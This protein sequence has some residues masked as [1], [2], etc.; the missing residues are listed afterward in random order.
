MVTARS[1]LK[2]L[3]KLAA[4]F[5]EAAHPRYP[6][7]H[8]LGGQFMRT[9]DQ[10]PLQL[11]NGRSIPGRQTTTLLELSAIAAD[12]TGNLSEDEVKRL[13]VV[14][15]GFD[16][17]ESCLNSPINKD[18]ILYAGERVVLSVISSRDVRFT[19]DDKYI[20][21]TD[22]D[23][24]PKPSEEL[25]GMQSIFDRLLVSKAGDAVFSN[26]PANES[27][28]RHE[29]R[30]KHYVKS[31]F[32]PTP[33]RNVYVLDNRK[34]QADFVECL[35]H[36]ELLVRGNETKPNPYHFDEDSN[37]SEIIVTDAQSAQI[38]ALDALLDRGEISEEEHIR[39]LTAL[40]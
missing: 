30:I 17:F 18:T 32:I 36:P 33:S 29:M 37:G 38:E 7:G 35:N 20:V 2:T 19:V 39:R 40:L 15:N 16:S 23:A 4:K 26:S 27:K 34:N 9:D 5:N 12:E 3:H 11:P 10:I 31:G 6:K 25:I 24:K 1:K 28:S 22:S 8:P 13:H 21:K 14:R